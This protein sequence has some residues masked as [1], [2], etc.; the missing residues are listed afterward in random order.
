MSLRQRLAALERRR[1][2]RPCPECGYGDVR[3]R[4]VVSYVDQDS[5]TVPPPPACPHCGRS[6]LHIIVQYVTP[7]LCAQ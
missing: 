4:A 1:Q 3:R 6:P 5:A 7:T 2:D